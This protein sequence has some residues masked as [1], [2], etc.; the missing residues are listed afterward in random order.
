MHERKVGR[1]A[2]ASRTIQAGN[3]RSHGGDAA[4]E[5]AG[6]AGASRQALVEIVPSLGVDHGPNDGELVHHLG[7][8]RHVL[9]DLDAWY[10]GAYGL[11][12][13]PNA[14]WGVGL[15]V[16][17]VVMWRPAG[18]EHVDDRLVRTSNARNPFG[19]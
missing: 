6:I 18:K 9:T 7:H 1:H 5:T 11:K 13:A 10:V 19:A 4:S 3:P 16:H 12:F 8:A 14:G 17:H 2:D 15:Q